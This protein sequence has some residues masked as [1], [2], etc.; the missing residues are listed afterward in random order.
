MKGPL[1]G[2]IGRYQVRDRLAEGGM[3]VLYLAVDPIIDRLVA[4]KL[5]RTGYDNELSERFARE[6]RAAGRLLH[7]NIIT[8]FDVGDHDGQPFIAM[9]YI[10]GETIGELVR[11]RA[12]LPLAR[13]VRLIADLCDGLSFA[14]RSGIVHR[15]IKPANIMV[16]REGI[17]K[18]LDFGIAHLADSRMTQTG[19]FMGTPAYMSPEQISG[20]VIDHRSD[21]FAVGLVLYELLVYRQAF[22][23]D[24]PIRI[25]HKILTED[26][27]SLVTVNPSLNRALVDIVTRAIQRDPDARY[28]D[29]SMMRAD[30]LKAVGRD[31]STSETIAFEPRRPTSAGPSTP[32][33]KS[34]ARRRAA[35]IEAH[36]TAAREAFTAGRFEDAIS[37]ADQAAVLDPDDNRAHDLIAQSREAILK[38]QV[39]GLL[40]K[41]REALARGALTDAANLLSQ[42][43]TAAP[44]DSQALEL[45]R[46]IRGIQRER[47]L[48]AER[49]RIIQRALDHARSCLSER[50][51]DSA[52]RSANE[53]LAQDPENEEAGRVKDQA[54]E[55]VAEE[56]RKD[57]HDRRARQ[58]VNVARA[59]FDAG[60]RTDAMTDLE[61]FDPPHDLVTGV[62]EDLRREAAAIQAR[63]LEAR[64]AAEARAADE[65]R[66]VA[67]AK[68]DE[69]ARRAA[70]ARAADEA[71]RAAA[72]K[73]ADEAR[74]AA[75]AKAAD[76]ARRAAEAKAAE[77]ARERARRAAEAKSAA[78]AREAVRREA[79]ARAAE[80]EARRGAFEETRFAETV[81]EDRPL[82]ETMVDPRGTW[83]SARPAAHAAP[84]PAADALPEL[85]RAAPRR[86][87]PITPDVP[88]RPLTKYIA[89]AMALAAVAVVA[90]V[91]LS[92]PDSTPLPPPSTTTTA[93]PSAPPTAPP[94][95][96]GPRLPVSIN[97]VPWASVRVLRDSV[98]VADG[99]TPLVVDLPEGDYS[100][101]FRNELFAP[102][103]R[104]LTVRSGQAA[105]L[106]VTL[107]GADLDKILND[108]LGPAQ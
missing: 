81:L 40:D 47:E 86:E 62:L 34:H 19:A 7:P 97:A 90:I 54:L 73:A 37:A 17:L 44:G 3:G 79:E 53:V 18:I 30:L 65:A 99:V 89:M 64:R 94:A 85:P 22:E 59:A 82:D 57:E 35:Q 107:P 98:V 48:L 41:A 69:E 49:K 93:T 100:L 96:T 91:F 87:I 103:T 32:D 31:E 5:L 83:H 38:Q 108:V 20:N 76:E 36:L 88:G 28:S 63:E 14:H 13:K 72:A 84:P 78:E 33:R 95:S 50:A 9:E 16:T 21:I 42:T 25:T 23:G 104:P 80:E 60:R 51:F 55:I 6:A 43:L 24:T 4:I 10:T 67:E 106:S 77:E 39:R 29:L 56:R 71:R 12:P 52:I 74:R 66:R 26:P 11:R 27:P 68:A 2:T 1:P 70:A 92:R 8:I 101:E 46:Q 61:R 75:E 58:A 102:V 105:A 15:D 45:Q